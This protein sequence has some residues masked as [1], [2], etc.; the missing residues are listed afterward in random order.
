MVE[1]ILHRLH[2][3]FWTNT[4]LLGAQLGGGLKLGDPKHSQI[5]RVVVSFQDPESAE[6][7]A[8]SER[9]GLVFLKIVLL[10]IIGDLHLK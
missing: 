10:Q 3:C 6:S 2:V 4:T 8:V 9:P 7:P 5:S 1:W